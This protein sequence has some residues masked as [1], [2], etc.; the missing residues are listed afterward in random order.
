MSK[1]KVGFE[2]SD[3]WSTEMFRNVI[4]ALQN[5]PEKIDDRLTAGDIELFLISTDDSSAYI[6]RTGAII[7][8]DTAHTIAC[9]TTAIKLSTI[10]TKKLDIYLDGMNPVVVSV[11]ELS[12][13]ADGILVDNKLNYYTTE[14]KWYSDMVGIIKRLLS[15]LEESSC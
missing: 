2:I 5:T 6:W 8:L 13:T 15:E 1:I 10:D 11:D 4:Y 9:A 12:D 3:L 7:G 14:L